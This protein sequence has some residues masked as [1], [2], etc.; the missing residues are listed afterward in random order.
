MTIY[1]MT[2]WYPWA[3]HSAGPNSGLKWYPIGF[4]LSKNV[5]IKGQES[6]LHV[7]WN[8]NGNIRPGYFKIILLQYI[9][10]SIRFILIFN[11]SVELNIPM[12][13][14]S[15]SCL[16]PVFPYL[17]KA[18]FTRQLSR[19]NTKEM[20]TFSFLTI[21]QSKLAV[22]WTQLFLWEIFPFFGI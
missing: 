19:I 7:R 20:E 4:R 13:D 15:E 21:H 6:N 5:D 17:Q 8:K 22:Y 2:M 14:I 12:T 9:C 18:V 10:I 16:K 1:T 3:R 11:N